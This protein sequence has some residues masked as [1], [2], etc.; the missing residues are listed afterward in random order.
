MS[1]AARALQRPLRANAVFSGA[2]GILL[3]LLPGW[4]ARQI[5]LAPAWLLA[6]LGLGLLAFAALVLW[7]SARPAERRGVI[8]AII[9]ADLGWVL[10]T[11]VVMVAGAAQVTAFGLGL[12]AGVATVVALF[13]ALQW[14]CWRR[15]A[16]VDEAADA[17]P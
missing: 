7:A 15:L 17:S 1:A 3:V 2:C 14:L 12:L 6:G 8:A 9:V 13:A 16:L 5:G 10:A 11:P 4:W